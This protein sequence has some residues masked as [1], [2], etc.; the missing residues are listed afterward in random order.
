MED[1]KDSTKG[2]KQPGFRQLS[3]TMVPIVAQFQ[4]D[5]AL[6]TV[7]RN[8]FVIYIR[9]DMYSI[10][11]ADRM[12]GMLYRSPIRT[13]SSRVEEYMDYQWTIYMTLI[14]ENRLESN[15]ARY[16]RGTEQII[17]DSYTQVCVMSY[18]PDIAP[19]DFKKMERKRLQEAFQ[20]LTFKQRQVIEHYYFLNKN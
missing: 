9:N 20:K 7:Y 10:F 2:V 12:K 8:S 3:D 11:A 13:T 4:M 18:T 5:D 19:T 14:A 17:E 15:Y 6:L 16:L 1:I